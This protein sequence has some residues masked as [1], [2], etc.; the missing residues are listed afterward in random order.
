MEPAALAT[1]EQV[2]ELSTQL[3]RTARHG[4][5]GL[6][7]RAG[8]DVLVTLRRHGLEPVK[9]ARQAACGGADDGGD[10]LL[11]AGSLS[12]GELSAALE[13]AC[14]LLRDGGVLVVELALPREGHAVW[15]DLLPRPNPG[16]G[17]GT[18]IDL[19]LR[20]NAVPPLG[21]ATPRRPRSL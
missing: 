12:L 9:R 14:P 5:L 15:P 8:L 18:A 10:L 13:R 2:V 16:A 7:A 21:E 3:A 1:A 17:A 20:K 19:S 11:V 6:A 4:R